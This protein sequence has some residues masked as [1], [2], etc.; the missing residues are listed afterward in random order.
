MPDS[1][2]ITASLVPLALTVTVPPGVPAYRGET[3]TEIFSD[4]SL[5]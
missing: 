1:S 2:L 4:P 3:L 5:P